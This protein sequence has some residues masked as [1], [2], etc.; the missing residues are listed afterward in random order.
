MRGVALTATRG[1]WHV[2]LRS[3]A[4]ALVG[5][6]HLDPADLAGADR[7]LEASI[8]TV[9]QFVRH[10]RP[11]ERGQVAGMRSLRASTECGCADPRT[12]SRGGGS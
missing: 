10:L 11:V 3:S 12:F 9:G 7:Q 4:P 5:E 1:D 2:R 8:S 6:S